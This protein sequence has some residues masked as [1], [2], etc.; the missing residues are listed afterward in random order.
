MATEIKCLDKGFVKLIDFMG[1]DKSIASAARVSYGNKGDRDDKNN[2][3]LIRYLMRNKHT[4]PFEMAE[5]ILHVKAPIFVARQW[6]RH[7]TASM[8]EISGRYTRITN[9]YYMPII[10]ELTTQ[11]KG[12]KQGRSNDVVDDAELV[13]EQIEQSLM[14]CFQQ[15]DLLVSRGL[16]KELARI[17]LP[18][19]T[20]TEFIWKIDLHN[21]F[22]FL[23][24]RMDKHAQKEMREY[25]AAIYGI[26][27]KLFPMSTKAFD[28][29]VLDAITM[30]RA[31]IYSLMQTISTQREYISEEITCNTELTEY[32]EKVAKIMEYSEAQN[33]DK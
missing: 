16:A 12:N 11:A 28:D 19:S 27:K 22:H 7:R 31:E 10:D 32:R 14:N 17:V 25:A 9:D 1:S 8:N 15:Y 21:L 3:R 5:I 23:K 18:L 24:L 2:E 6:V 30:T 13:N 4:S 20:Y 26:V 29:Y 33:G